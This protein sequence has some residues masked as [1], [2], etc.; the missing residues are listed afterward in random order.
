MRRKIGRR[1]RSLALGIFLGGG[2]A[3]QGGTQ[4]PAPAPSAPAR[5]SLDAE[6]E[7]LFN[8]GQDLLGRADPRTGGSFANARA[9]IARYDAALARDPRLAIAYV[10]IARAWMVQG[11][12]NPD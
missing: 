2:A 8:E 4:I 6:A 11:Y 9:A 12:S 7:R 10:Q 1:I 5:H 3:A